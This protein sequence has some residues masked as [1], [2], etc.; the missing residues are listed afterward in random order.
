MSEWE[1]TK[2]PSIRCPACGTEQ[3]VTASSGI[4]FKRGSEITCLGCKAAL[5]CTGVEIVPFWTWER[6]DGGAV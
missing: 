3:Y 5:K 4:E 2:M 1:T 6:V